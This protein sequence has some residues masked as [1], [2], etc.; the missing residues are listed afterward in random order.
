VPPGT[1]RRIA[2]L[3]SAG[4]LTVHRGCVAAASGDRRGVRVRI[5][6]GGSSTE[7]AAGSVIN[8]TGPAADIT[9]TG[10]PLLRGQGDES[11]LQ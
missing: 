2:A 7:L 8:C 6:H 1:A 11:S 10:D 5:D 4:R 3:T 9:T